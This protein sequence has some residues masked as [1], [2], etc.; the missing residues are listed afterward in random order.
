M[1]LK[2]VSQVPARHD[3][4]AAHT[5]A[6]A[7]LTLWEQRRK[8]R[9]YL[10]AMGTDFA[11]LKVPHVWYDILHVTEVLSSFVWLRDDPRLAAMVEIVKAKAGD[12]GRFISES[13]W[14][15]WKDWD[16]GQKREPSPWLTFSARRMLA[17]ARRPI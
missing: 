10:F 7:L 13:V 8:R 17:R 1:M 2:A 12:D 16:F 9:P 3:S 6:E 5:G 4:E 11:K 14:M 15:A